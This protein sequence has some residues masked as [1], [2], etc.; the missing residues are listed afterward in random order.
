MAGHYEDVIAMFLL[1]IFLLAVEDIIAHLALDAYVRDESLGCLG[2]H[3]RLVVGIG[4]AIRVAVLAVE[5]VHEVIAVLDHAHCRISLS[6]FNSSSVSSG[7]SEVSITSASSGLKAFFGR[8][9]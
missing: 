9:P 4:I 6:S 1:S 8:N 7:G 5:V 3:A 2:V